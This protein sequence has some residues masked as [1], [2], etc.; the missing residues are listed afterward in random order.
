[1]SHVNAG[2]PR[3]HTNAAE[4][5]RHA[6]AI[7]EFARSLVLEDQPGGVDPCNECVGATLILALG[8][9]TKQIA[10]GQWADE[11]FGLARR[12]DHLESICGTASDLLKT[13]AILSG[14]NPHDYPELYEAA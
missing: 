12:F 14:A 11:K 2:D 13:S 5:D 7:V 4:K 8:V 1:M 10:K 9:L 6:A 3:A